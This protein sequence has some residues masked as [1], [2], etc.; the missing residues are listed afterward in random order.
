MT[1]YNGKKTQ[2]RHSTAPANEQINEKNV[3][4]TFPS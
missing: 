4:P 1:Q 3:H 2:G